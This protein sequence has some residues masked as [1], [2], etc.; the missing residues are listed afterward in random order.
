LTHT[1][2]PLSNATRR[3]SENIYRGV[4]KT[5][6][7]VLLRDI[8]ALEGAPKP[9]TTLRAHTRTPWAPPL[10]VLAEL[11]RMWPQLQFAFKG[12]DEFESSS[13]PRSHK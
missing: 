7:D 13:R 11:L 6:G 8:T 9:T 12:C 4:I 10:P 1:R 2:W 3:Q 5:A